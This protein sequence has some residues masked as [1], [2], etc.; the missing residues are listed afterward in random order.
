MAEF[1]GRQTEVPESQT[2]TGF[3][4]KHMFL[5]IKQQIWIIGWNSGWFLGAF[6]Q[7]MARCYAELMAQI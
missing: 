4:G 2:T 6:L 3:G 5:L 7:K 1:L